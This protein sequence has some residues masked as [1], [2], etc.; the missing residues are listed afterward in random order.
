MG[1]YLSRPE[2]ELPPEK[3]LARSRARFELRRVD[4]VGWTVDE[5]D[6]RLCCGHENKH[7][8][9]AHYGTHRCAGKYSYCYG[10]T[11][12][13]C[14]N[15]VCLKSRPLCDKHPEG[16][17]I[18][19]RC[20][21][22]KDFIEEDRTTNLEFDNT[23]VLCADERCAEWRRASAKKKAREALETAKREAIKRNAVA[24]ASRATAATSSSSSGNGEWR[25][26]SEGSEQSSVVVLSSSSSAST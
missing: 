1:S 25:V 10:K 7:G 12:D 13:V 21:D 26:W 6:A 4:T 22:I 2:R 16:P 17:V 24:R 9:K 5:L 20:A 3:R 14:T 19:T 11:Y 8:R 15:A 18:C 23:C